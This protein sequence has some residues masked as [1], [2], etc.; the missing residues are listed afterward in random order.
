MPGR[1]AAR[2][3]LD[4]IT[5]IRS[6]MIGQLTCTMKT[7]FQSFAQGESDKEMI[8]VRAKKKIA[9]VTS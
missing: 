7:L 5:K 3:R 2:P 9:P 4:A 1:D 8:C 6:L